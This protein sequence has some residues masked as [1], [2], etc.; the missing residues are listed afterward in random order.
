MRQRGYRLSLKSFIVAALFLLNGAYSHS[1]HR[2]V[3]G[4]NKRIRFAKDHNFAF[5]N[6]VIADPSNPLHLIGCI[7]TM[8]PDT[9]KHCMNTLI[10]SNDG[11]QSWSSEDIPWGA[12]P[13]C[14]LLPNGDISLSYIYGLNYMLATKTSK[15]SNAGGG[16]KWRSELLLGSGYDHNMLIT[17]ASN[18]PFKGCVYLI[19]TQS[20]RE[21]DHDPFVLI[22]RSKDGGKTF[23]QQAR[24]HPFVNVDLNAK[25]P[26]ILEDGTLTI[27]ILVRGQYITS[28]SKA[29]PLSSATNWLITSSD[30]GQTFS[31]PMLI[32]SNSGDGYHT[33]SVDK[34]SKWRGRLYYV[35]NGSEQKGIYIS[36][37]N[38]KGESWTRAQR[39]DPSNSNSQE[40]IVASVTV[41]EMNGIVGVLY[42]SREDIR[43]RECY[44]L[45][46]TASTDGGITFLKPTR[47]NS[48]NSC[49]DKNAGWFVNAWP[50][51]GD[52]C[53]LLAKP[54]GS[55]LAI[56][57]DARTGSFKLYQSAISIK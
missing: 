14:A 22:A 15:E 5:E 17:D 44:N 49:P 35:F 53:S 43:D 25:T 24:Y 55:F 52:Y 32:S 23:D 57:S 54:D 20:L 3:I 31:A 30:G 51:G 56:W 47:V 33:L 2:I 10:E 8:C 11:G 39:I 50:Q 4:E 48:Q 19:S 7:L 34:S 9:V 27:P 6:T 21:D 28:E 40:D 42:I 13:W 18:G 36:H 38:D 16:R 12:N 29:V 1:Q 45:Y 26:V 41:N 37:T 46:F